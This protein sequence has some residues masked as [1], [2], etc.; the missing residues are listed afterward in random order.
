MNFLLC[1]P[2]NELINWHDDD[3]GHVANMCSPNELIEIICL[4]ALNN[5]LDN[6]YEYQELILTLLYRKSQGEYPVDLEHKFV[7]YVLSK[8]PIILRH[9]TKVPNYHDSIKSI[10]DKDLIYI[11]LKVDYGNS[12]M[13]I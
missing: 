9:L 6:S 2:Y 10:I 8:S 4:T 3:L 11:Y 1:I 13:C 12:H 5:D 7:N